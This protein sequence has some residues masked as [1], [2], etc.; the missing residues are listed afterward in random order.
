M[1]KCISEIADFH[2]DICTILQL[3]LIYF[4]LSG[5]I[6]STCVFSSLS[7]SI[8][9][10]ISIPLSFTLSTH[11]CF[12]EP[13]AGTVIN[14]PSCGDPINKLCTLFAVPWWW[15]SHT[16]S[17]LTSPAPLKT[18]L[19]LFTC[20]H[21][22]TKIQIITLAP[23][24]QP[25]HCDCEFLPFNYSLVPSLEL[26]PCRVVIARHQVGRHPD[27]LWSGIFW[28]TIEFRVEKKKSYWIMSRICACVCACACVCVCL[29][30]TMNESS[31]RTLCSSILLLT[32]YALLW[33][34]IYLCKND[35]YSY[36]A[37]SWPMLFTRVPHINGSFNS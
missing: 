17:W 19:L 13:P 25:H 18:Q 30:Q 27:F 26:N 1:D 29:M 14:S 20:N 12:E 33:Q 24:I 9:F 15:W 2:L 31:G 7:Y 23:S 5:I 3:L 32:I 8:S 4:P 28:N 16:R 22:L 34:N 36:I 10:H 35:I 21:T 6:A 37:H 11:N